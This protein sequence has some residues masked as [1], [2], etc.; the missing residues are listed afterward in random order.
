MPGVAEPRCVKCRRILTLYINIPATGNF[1]GGHT[2]GTAILGLGLIGVHWHQTRMEGLRLY[3]SKT[4]CRH[5][6]H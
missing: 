1:S 5:R 4:I 2:N 3:Y 6:L